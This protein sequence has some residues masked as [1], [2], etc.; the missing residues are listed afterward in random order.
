[1][2]EFD[3]SRALLIF[4]VIMLGLYSVVVVVSE[5]FI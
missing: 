5:R 4:Q 1:M 2:E 3:F